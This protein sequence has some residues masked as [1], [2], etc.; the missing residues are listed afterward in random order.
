[1]IA[2]G[3]SNASFMSKCT[4]SGTFGSARPGAQ[5]W[6]RN[7]AESIDGGATGPS[8]SAAATSSSQNS[9]LPFSADEQ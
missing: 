8:V 5:W 6:G 1:M 9:G 3:R 2:S 7:H 4:W